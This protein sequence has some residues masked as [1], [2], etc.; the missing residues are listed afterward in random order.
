MP[1]IKLI[2]TTMLVDQYSSLRSRLNGKQEAE[3]E[4]KRG[5]FSKVEELGFASTS[6]WQLDLSI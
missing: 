1:V 2:L 5:M 4:Y 6:L 3:T